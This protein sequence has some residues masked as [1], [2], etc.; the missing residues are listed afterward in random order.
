M[1]DRAVRTA[2]SACATPRGL[3]DNTPEP[4]VEESPLNH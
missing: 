1:L 2:S 3:L 4:V